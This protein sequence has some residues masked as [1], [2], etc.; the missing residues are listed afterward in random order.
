MLFTPVILVC[1]ISTPTMCKPVMGYTE[2]TE[3]E[4]M[5]SLAQ[6]VSIVGRLPDQYVAGLACI[7]T[8]LLD[9]SVSTK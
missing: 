5:E 3:A 1:F 8:H 9:E 7:E 4:C 6:G 2:P